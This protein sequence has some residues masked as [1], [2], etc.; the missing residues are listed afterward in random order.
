MFTVLSNTRNSNMYIVLALAI[1]LVVL[2]TFAVAP[3]IAA[4]KPAL[5]PVTGSRMR[6]ANSC[7]VRRPCMQV[8]LG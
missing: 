7:A 3:S 4:P 1:T 8:R 5:S 6:M 2:L